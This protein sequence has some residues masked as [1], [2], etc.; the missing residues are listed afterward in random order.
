L[1]AGVAPPPPTARG[2]R[3]ASVLRRRLSLGRRGDPAGTGDVPGGRDGAGSAGREPRPTGQERPD[4]LAASLSLLAATL[5]STADGI[6]VVDRDGRV[7]GHNTRFQ[8][9]WG[10]PAAVRTGDEETSL[11][12]RATERVAD[13][14][15]FRARVAE[16][17]AQPDLVATDEV[18]LRDGRVF[19]RY[20]QPQRIDGVVVGRVWSFRDRTAE[21]RLEQDLRRMAFTDELTGLPN[22]A[23][24][25]T[26][27]GRWPRTPRRRVSRWASRCSTWTTSR[28][29]TTRSGTAR[30][31]S[32]WG[33]RRAGCARPPAQR[34]SSPASAE[35][36]SASCCR[37]LPPPPWRRC[38][39]A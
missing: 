7:V 1:E 24:F 26:R 30:A 15:G 18:E 29:S 12:A 8:L 9:L 3:A 22:R 27:G 28:P 4:R 14:A 21:R 17:Y 2:S 33:S 23:L 38:S 11:L 35:T 25:M 34:T 13:P 19:S 20:T 5:E 6:L 36:S 31:T 16:L 37:E 32:C 10:L 39:S